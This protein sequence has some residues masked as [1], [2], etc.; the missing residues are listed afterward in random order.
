MKSEEIDRLLDKYLAEQASEE[1]IML[2]E[3]WYESFETRPGIV[4]QMHK[5]EKE[6]SMNEGFMRIKKGLESKE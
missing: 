1:E 3:A 5:E 6:Q 4:E 2:V